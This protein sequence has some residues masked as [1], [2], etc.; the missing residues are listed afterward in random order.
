M[1][2]ACARVYRI[3]VV[4]RPASLRAGPA[5]GSFYPSRTAQISTVLRS[6][7]TVRHQFLGEG[8]RCEKAERR[9]ASSASNLILDRFGSQ[10]T[11][12]VDSRCAASNLAGARKGQVEAPLETARRS[13]SANQE[14]PE[15]PRSLS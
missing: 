13:N 3:A 12:A 14:R 8:V 4:R 2:R 10:T 9:I 6:D 7:L 1:R 11:S 15:S 5:V